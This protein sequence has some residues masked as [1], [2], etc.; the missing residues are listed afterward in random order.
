MQLP[1]HAPRMY[2]THARPARLG[3][4][5]PRSRRALD[6]AEKSSREQ[7]ALLE[8]TRT[9]LLVSTVP[10]AGNQ[11]AAAR[12]NR[13]SVSSCMQI[14]FTQLILRISPPAEYEFLISV[15]QIHVPSYCAYGELRAAG[16][17][18]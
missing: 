18:A 17:S 12:G 7:Q 15:F 8:Y 11:Q 10:G 13:Q 9:Y 14:S 1:L 6:T 3:K 4:I 2:S 5:F 16:N